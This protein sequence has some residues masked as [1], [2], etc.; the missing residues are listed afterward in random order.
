[1]IDPLGAAVQDVFVLTM[2]SFI[3]VK[4]QIPSEGYSRTHSCEVVGSQ[5]LV[6]GGYPPGPIETNA[7]CVK[8]LIR[9]FDLNNIGWTSEYKLGTEYRTPRAV[10]DGAGELQFNSTA[11]AVV[12]GWVDDDLQAAFEYEIKKLSHSS[13]HKHKNLKPLWALIIIPVAMV[14][15]VLSRKWE[16][17]RVVPLPPPAVPVIAEMAAEMPAPEQQRIQPGPLPPPGEHNVG[18]ER[19]PDEKP[20]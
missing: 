11:P 16:G 20:Q 10:V 3:W 18:A 9:I 8:E 15:V 2:P 17:G 6:V 7:T 14:A 1:L 13:P 12:G 4:I 5:L 19:E